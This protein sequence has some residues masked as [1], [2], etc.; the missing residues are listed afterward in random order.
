V[1]LKNPSALVA[2][3]YSITQRKYNHVDFSRSL[4][5]NKFNKTLEGGA[6]MVLNGSLMS[7]DKI[8]AHIQKGQV[9]VIEHELLPFYLARG[10]SFEDWLISRAVDSSRPNSRLLKKLLKLKHTDDL[11]TVLYAHAATV[12]DN[13]W[14]RFE[15]EDL[16]WDKVR[17]RENHFVDLAL[18]GRF[19]EIQDNKLEQLRHS[20]TPELTNIGSFEKAWKLEGG[21]WYL[22]KRGTSLE[23]FSELFIYA[24]GKQLGFDMAE[25]EPSEGYV[26]SKDFTGGIYNFDPT[27]SIVDDSVDEVEIYQKLRT[28]NPS[29]T[30]AYLDIVYLDALVFN[31]DRHTYN[32]GFLR[33]Q[34][35]GAV[36]AMA[37]NFDNNI[38]LISRGYGESP[39]GTNGILIQDF[40]T[41]LN[42]INETYSVPEQQSR[43]MLLQLAEAILPEEDIN[44][45]FVVDLV[46]DRQTR[47]KEMIE[48]SAN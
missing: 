24:L 35:T 29:L 2:L 22:Y 14:F 9:Q 3:S 31:V 5:Y 27:A 46:L 17:F 4:G 44:R 30:K 23:R 1:F 28:L 34:E 12:T 48:N 18:S 15:H 13:L 33:N 45:A 41:L 36:I 6:I 47:L 7:G 25:Y 16:T 37:P 32:F 10:G 38:A 39:I 20:R 11:N 43:E 26:K 42:E 8:I 40:A 19:L 21:T